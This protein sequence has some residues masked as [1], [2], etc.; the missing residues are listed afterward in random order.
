MSNE[1]GY[2]S[3][4]N[5]SCWWD[6]STLH[7]NVTTDNFGTGDTSSDSKPDNLGSIA[8]SRVQ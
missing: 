7:G 5:G 8:G 6:A 3:T 4:Y 2:L 1:W